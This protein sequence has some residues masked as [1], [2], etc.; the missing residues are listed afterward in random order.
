MRTVVQKSS[1]GPAF[2]PYTHPP[3]SSILRTPLSLVKLFLL[4]DDILI[5][6]V[7]RREAKDKSSDRNHDDAKDHEPMPAVTKRSTEKCTDWCVSIF[8]G[9]SINM[10]TQ[11]TS[12]VDKMEPQN[13]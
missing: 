8:F 9:V 6:G 5:Y 12:R 4:A 2:L 10:K 13:G 1:T 11:T 7:G 3:L